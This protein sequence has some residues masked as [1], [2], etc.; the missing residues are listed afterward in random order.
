MN[1]QIKNQMKRL[2][3][4]QLKGLKKYLKKKKNNLLKIKKK[5]LVL[6]IRVQQIGMTK[7]SSIKY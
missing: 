1:I 2:K 5:H 6:T 4:V 7:I 3:T